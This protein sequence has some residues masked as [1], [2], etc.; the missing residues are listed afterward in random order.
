MN[1]TLP[2]L[3]RI[4]QS[5]RTPKLRTMREFAEQEIVIPTGPYAGL[6]FNCA[7]QPFTR[8]WFEA[9]DSGLWRR[10]ATTGPSQT[11]KTFLAFV[12]PTLYHLFEVAETSIIGLPSLDIA[13]DKWTE[14]I[15]PAIQ[16]SRYR[17]L[18]PKSG[19][20]SRGGRS[21]MAS[22]RFNHGVT[23]RFMTGGGD[24]KS[25]AAFTS[26]VLLTTETDG[27]DLISEGSREA[28]KVAQLE[29][30]TQAFGDRARIYHECTVSLEEGRIWQEVTK[31][32]DSR[33]AIR[34]AH[35]RHHV[36]PEREHLIGWREAQDELEAG[37]KGH[38]VCPS[39]G[40]PWTED[41]RVAANH[42]CLLV[43]RGQEITPEGRITAPPPRTETLGFRW[44]S[45]NNLLVKTSAVAK[46][47]WRA[48]RSADEDNAD[49]ELNQ[50]W[51]A[52][53]YKPSA[54]SLTAL[55]WQS[56]ARRMTD[57]PRGRVPSGYGRITIGIDVGKYYLHWTAVAWGRHATPHVI[58]YGRREVAT[59]ELGE[60]KAILTAL[61]DFR[62]S[63]AVDGWPADEGIRVPSMVA[64]DVGY[65][66]DVVLKFC[67]ESANYQA[68][69]GFGVKQIGNNRRVGEKT[70]SGWSVVWVPTGAGYELVQHPAWR[71]RMLQVKADHWKTWLHA[72]IQTPV[73]QHGAL[74]LHGGGDHLGFAKH[75]TAEKKIE[76]FV[77]GKG[78]VVRWE[79]VN[80]NN[81]FLDSTALA[82]AVAHAAGERLMG[83]PVEQGTTE[84]T[85]GE[86]SISAS[87]FMNRG[88][89][90]W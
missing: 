75:L 52:K 46:K 84:E 49:K 26:R 28:D 72:R 63:V 20:G 64:V 43:H 73:K 40:S 30:R 1:P 51:W 54:V 2:L 67:E 58:E 16:A 60:E 71:A 3:T 78:L 55:D 76:E 66:Q 48:S 34:C 53:P 59:A 9:V 23:L 86:G 33:I 45:V 47:E 32:T 18:L 85:S 21:N 27:L 74:T 29:A 77:P 38:L 13:G 14:D 44:N 89:N 41:E 22:V 37:D 36:T 82:C 10:T 17:E 11:G 69:K 80:R 70:E 90:K 50:F 81:H 87:Q 15:L 56:I 31:G 42:D 68:C 39:C 62:D 25:R 24:D 88:R 79:Q 83:E 12:I 65:H 35:C 57:D 8:L 4:A 5:I 6:K 19:P 7:R 61:R